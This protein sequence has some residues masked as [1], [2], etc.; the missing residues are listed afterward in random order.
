MA[1]TASQAAVL[2]AAA[3]LGGEA[4]A[5]QIAAAAGVPTRTATRA[6][7]ALRDAG[8]LE[9]AK[10]GKGRVRLTP[11]GWAARPASAAPVS[12]GAVVDEA[13]DLWASL[14]MYAHRAFLELLLSAVIGRHHI[15][16]GKPDRH[17]AFVAVGESGTGK[18][19]L[20]QMACTVLGLDPV[21]HELYVPAQAPGSVI[22][23]RVRADGGF[24]WEP[25]P[26]AGRPLVLFDEFDKADEAVRKA[27]LPYLDGRVLVQFEGERCR[28]CPTP[29]LAGNPPR[30]GERLGH[31]RAEFRRR[32]VLL[33][34]GY[35]AHR[36][37]DLE[38]ALHAFY[39]QRRPHLDLE[40]LRP[41]ATVPPV[42]R[43]LLGSLGHALTPAGRAAK[44]PLA[45][46]EAA[47]LGRAAL[48]G[49]I[50]EHG[51]VLAA[52]TVS[53]AY[54]TVTE[55]LSGEVAPAWHLDFEAIREH[56]DGRD[57]VDK[58]EQVVA[59][60]RAARA[61]AH[62]R[63]ARA[64]VAGEVE[65]LELTGAKHELAEQLR[66]AAER[67]DGRRMPGT[68]DK[69]TAA[70]LRAQLRKARTEVL[71]CR[72]HGRLEDMRT[73]TA[74]P[75]ARARELRR[76]IDQEAAD[77]RQAARQAASE[78]QRDRRLARQFE[79]AMREQQQ[80]QR[81]AAKSRLNE[82]RAAARDG[83]RLWGRRSTINSQQ[84]CQVL[85]RLGLLRFEAA[86]A[87]ARRGSLLRQLGSAL[88]GDVGGGRWVSTGDPLVSFRGTRTT[89][90]QLVQWGESTRA[91]LLPWLLALHAEEDGLVDRY[92]LRPR[93][94]RPVLHRPK[95][96]PAQLH[97]LAQ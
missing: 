19:A 23:R 94:A 16:E 71:D 26:V 1:L 53:V 17:L 76:R 63:V 87:H 56:L 80:A 18:S 34:T 52:F 44:P 55:Q 91:V 65:N 27:L 82:V 11:S 67:I 28:L 7:T 92:G 48:A 3:D 72:A 78:R 33:D 21:D 77:T 46:L 97:G 57:D 40:Q 2:E 93:A 32:S 90:P 83:E 95:V 15:G 42:A 35:A 6:L 29:M 74:G 88:T 96:R 49:D 9:G 86:P 31:I 51:L 61:Q 50:T 8:L 24:G 68:A 13:L 89:C 64:R 70:A 62:A 4:G 12:A 66:L 14:G 47:T 79:D 59:G 43:D 81:E 58:L 84:P 36:G 38:H 37:T 5:G 25:A 54:L 73:V 20:A 30:A 45:A 41:P 22:G 10:G 60:S 75:L 39:D 85:E 69:T